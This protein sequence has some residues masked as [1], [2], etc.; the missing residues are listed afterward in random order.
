[1]SLLEINNLHVRFGAGATAFRAVQGL[2]LRLEVGETLGIVGE[3]GSGKS[4]AMMA[5]MGLIE[6]PGQVTAERLAFVGNDLLCA[7]PA[8]RRRMIGK[9]LSMVFQDPV[10]SLNPAYTI[11]S[12]IVET[13]KTHAPAS[14]RAMKVRAEELLAAVGIPEPKARLAAYPHQLSGGLCQRAMIAMAIACEPKLLIADEPTTAL[15]VTVQA[16]IIDLLLELQVRHHMGLILI[17]H[18][19]AVVSQI[20]DRVIVMYAGEVVEEAPART[21]FASPKH[22]YTAALLAAI[23]ENNPIGAPLYS[24]PGLV[25]GNLERQANRCLMANRCDRVREEC[26]L[27][28]PCLAMDAD[29][30]I[31]RCIAPLNGGQ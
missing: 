27:E 17:S 1:M 25:P 31:V 22:P 20:A 13:L 21:L 8:A 5:L 26:L 11:G 3:S 19:L 29:G 10:T 23:P 4:V 12:Q 6:T 14:R 18:N 24:L 2:D 30:R 16:Q 28:R 9:D 7:R 15:D